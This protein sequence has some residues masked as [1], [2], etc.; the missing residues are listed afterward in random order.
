MKFKIKEETREKAIAFA[1]A[2]IAIVTFYFLVSNFTPIKTFFK[3]LLYILMPFI[4]GF[5][6]AFLMSGVRDWFYH[7][8]FK[9]WDVRPATKLKFSV[10][11]SMI[12]LT[13]CIFG[14]IS[15]LVNQVSTSIQTFFN[16]FTGSFESSSLYLSEVIEQ[17]HLSQELFDWII[18][19]GQQGLLQVMETLRQQMPAILSY[20]FFVV[21]QV[22]N[23]FVGLVV[24]TYLLY[25]R[26][27]FYLNTKRVLY[28]VLPQKNVDWLVELT[29]IC[30]RMFNSFIVGKMIDSLIIGI[31]CYIGM[32]I[33]NLD[34]AIL[35]S[36]IVGVTNMIPIFGPFIGAV[37]GFFILLIASPQDSLTFVLWII[38]LQQFD[39]NILGPK[40]LGDSMGLPT[41]WIMFA[42]IVGGA[43][44]GFIGMFLGVPV[45][46]VVYFL[47]MRNVKRRLELKK[48]EIE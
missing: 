12:I 2:G 23:F 41:V 19:Y 44:F 27:K 39:G 34:F 31:L 47:V 17:L 3:E 18:Y 26:E 33:L 20:S 25:D 8:V 6:F 16:T 10:G 32:M 35:I 22:F 14:F 13:L 24:A 28:A 30:S 7:K 40:I 11:L 4:L 29:H 21:R 15:L 38:A 42:I 5:F 43:F 9:K 46:S 36:F 37:P 1:L 45:F 48:I